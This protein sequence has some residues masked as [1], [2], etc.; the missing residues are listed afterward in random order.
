M[1]RHFFLYPYPSI[2]FIFVSK[3]YSL[4]KSILLLL[5][6]LPFSAFAQEEA[7]ISI[8]IDSL[9]REDQVYIG[10]TFNLLSNRVPDFSQNGLSAGVQIGFIRDMPI[11]KARNKA[12]GIGLGLALDTYNQNLFIGENSDGTAG[13][14]DIVGNNSPSTGNRFTYYTLDVPLEYRWR[15]STPTKYSFWRI[16]VGTRIGYIFRFKSSYEEADNNSIQT[17]IKELNKL[18]YGPTFSFGYGAF[19]FQAYYGLNTL[20]NENAT[21]N[22]ETVDLQVIKLGLIFYFL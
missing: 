1:S 3:M 11:N 7:D 9:Y 18:Q 12:I 19:N 15:T 8:L 20:F 22:N 14:F 5:V 17:D 4:L 16:H 13:E 2:Y 21:I 10:L 6:L